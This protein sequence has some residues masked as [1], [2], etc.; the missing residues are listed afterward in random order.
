[1]NNDK[2]LKKE[3]P[4]DLYGRYRIIFDIINSNS[5]N[6]EEKILDVGGRGNLLKRFFEGNNNYSVYYLDPLVNTEDKNYIE[7]DGT[8]MPLD[9]ESFDWVVSADVLE[10]IIPEKRIDFLN[11]KLRVAKRGVILVAPFKSKNT[12]LAE[13]SANQIYKNL[14]GND[15]PWLI[16]HINNGLPETSLVENFIQETKLDYFKLYNNNLQ[17]WQFLVGLQCVKD[18]LHTNNNHEILDKFGEFNEFYNNF[19]FP[20]DS[21]QNSYRHI[22]VIKK[23]ST[24]ENLVQ[25]ESNFSDILI[26]R[27]YN[28]YYK[29][30][31]NVLINFQNE[32][33]LTQ[34]QI[35]NFEETIQSELQEKE[36]I[37]SI[38][39]ERD[40]K[41]V[42]TA[43]TIETLTQSKDQQIAELT[44]K[45]EELLG[46]IEEKDRTLN[47]QIGES[48]NK[49]NE[50][51][52]KDRKLNLHVN[53]L[54]N[55]NN[56]LNTQ[57]ND[58]LVKN[59]KIEELLGVIEER[60]RTLNLQIGEITK[61]EQ[62]I[63]ELLGVI[64][65]K[66]IRL[67]IKTGELSIEEQK[68]QELLIII[69]EKGNKI[70][71]L[72]NSYQNLIN[73]IYNKEFQM[74]KVTDTNQKLRCEVV[75]MTTSKFW[76]LRNIYLKLKFAIITPD[77]FIKKYY[78]KIKKKGSRTI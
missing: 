59:N 28:E 73:D 37:F 14:F 30:I 62:R 8:N 25:E 52:D 64:E 35:T 13:I 65:D 45:T 74:I 1:M 24:I 54:F 16:E 49:D 23:D 78:N 38:I 26:Y 22:Y 77:K 55:K 50:I 58:L 36:K 53:E 44:V 46:V 4:F 34:T 71:D 63:E 40:Q 60:D 56:A 66:D 5:E 15:H 48:I 70:Q 9:D 39:K 72:N 6:K 12:E 76:K 32:K 7:G 75:S 27:T 47:L 21:N 3:L 10:H 57:N 11:E 41:L 61:K 67:N 33:K 20:K 19:V 2:Q 31:N 69:Q 17:I 42:E 43:N 29:I 51:E 18:Y 68:I